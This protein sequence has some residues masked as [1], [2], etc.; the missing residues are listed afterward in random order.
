MMA[1]QQIGCPVYARVIATIGTRPSTSLA[2]RAGQAYASR[3]IAV[4]CRGGS[5]GSS[6]ERTHQRTIVPGPLFTPLRRYI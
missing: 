1:A 3:P 5:A 4:S 2:M 6:L